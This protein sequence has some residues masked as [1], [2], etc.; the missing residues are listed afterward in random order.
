M[1]HSMVQYLDIKYR[2]SKI[3][4][5]IRTCT[6]GGKKKKTREAQHKDKQDLYTF[7]K[8][9]F[10]R[11]RVS[12]VGL[13]RLQLLLLI[14]YCSVRGTGVEGTIIYSFTG[15]SFGCETEGEQRENRLQLLRQNTVATVLFLHAFAASFLFLFP[16]FSMLA[17]HLSLLET[18]KLCDRAPAEKQRCFLISSFIINYTRI[19]LLK[20]VPYYQR[21][22][23]AC[24]AAEGM[25]TVQARLAHQFMVSPI[26]CV[27]L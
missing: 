1:T 11:T 4:A 25:N 22:F 12:L 5:K 16:G 9:N 19:H 17:P 3:K 14:R 8:N 20:K 27:F 18:A 13:Q 21:F 23:Y 24:T 15:S 2:L 26:R 7:R 10:G 6:P